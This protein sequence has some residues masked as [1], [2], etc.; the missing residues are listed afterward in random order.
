MVVI[1]M[2]TLSMSTEFHEKRVLASQTWQITLS[3]SLKKD[4]MQF[5]EEKYY[6]SQ[7]S[8][9]KSNIKRCSSNVAQCSY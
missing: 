6:A 5:Y 8:I 1:I 3:S 4:C 9:S 7:I 2:S